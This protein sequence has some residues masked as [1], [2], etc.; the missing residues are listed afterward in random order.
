MFPI[1]DEPENLNYALVKHV[2]KSNLTKKE[3]DKFLE[4]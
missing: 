3:I 1:G 2:G 4:K